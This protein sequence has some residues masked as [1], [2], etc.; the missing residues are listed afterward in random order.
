MI[1]DENE[2]TEILDDRSDEYKDLF[3]WK[4]GLEAQETV[5]QF[6]RKWKQLTDR[7]IKEFTDIRLETGKQIRKDFKDE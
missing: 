3:L 1:I 6:M 7:L 2:A 4:L 5:E